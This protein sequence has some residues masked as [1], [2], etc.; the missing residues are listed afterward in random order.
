MGRQTHDWKGELQDIIN[1]HNDRHAVKAKGVSFATMHVWANF[2]FRLVC[3]PAGEHTPRRGL[4]L[5]PFSGGS[6]WLARRY[7]RL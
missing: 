3:R 5:S 6:T 1:R 4:V 2:L 7:L